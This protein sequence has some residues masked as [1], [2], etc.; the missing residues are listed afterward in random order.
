MNSNYRTI[1]TTRLSGKTRLCAPRVPEQLSLE[2]NAAEFL[3]DFSLSRPVIIS[4]SLGYDQAR[5]ILLDTHS[6]YALIE[7]REHNLV[8]L[9]TLKDLLGLYSM[10][11]AE[12]YHQPLKSLTTRELMQPIDQ[13]TAI[14][15]DTV[16]GYKLGD[17]IST[18]KEKGVNYLLVTGANEA[19]LHGLFS[20]DAIGAALGEKIEI[21]FHATSLADFARVINGHYQAI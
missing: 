8:G 14:G 20:A 9:L 3:V 21:G 2:A 17:V 12:E 7:D 1:G 18:F 5:E 11:R 19:S 4:D 13:L 15:R 10:I 6:E 16:D